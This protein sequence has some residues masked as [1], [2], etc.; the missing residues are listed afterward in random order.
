[1]ILYFKVSIIDNDVIELISKFENYKNLLNTDSIFISKL[2]EMD[3]DSKAS[4][5]KSKDLLFYRGVFLLDIVDD[6]YHIVYD[7]DYLGKLNL[8]I[9]NLNVNFV[10]IKDKY[11]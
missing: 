4:R 8:D 9:K 6:F 3:I 10:D 7:T 5:S 11:K 1:M 2:R